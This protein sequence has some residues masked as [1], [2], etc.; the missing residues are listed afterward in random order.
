M[1]EPVW[2]WGQHAGQRQPTAVPVAQIVQK[3]A[4]VREEQRKCTPLIKKLA[5]LAKRQVS[6]R[7][8]A[9]PWSIPELAMHRV[10]GKDTLCVF[11]IEVDRPSSLPVVVA[12]PDEKLANRT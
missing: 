6:D 5:I 11:P 7:K 8:V 12:Q 1:R 10:R 9:N 4:R 2:L 3:S